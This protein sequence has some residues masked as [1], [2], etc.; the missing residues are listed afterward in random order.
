MEYAVAT[1]LV[2]L[3]IVAAIT[4]FRI[5][6]QHNHIDWEHP[7]A[8]L[9]DGWNRW[10]C[11]SYHRLRAQPLNLPSHGGAIIAANHFSG[12]D[13]FIVAALSPRPVRFLIA[14]EEYQRFGLQ[15]LFRAAGCIP[16]ERD[17][18]PQKAFRAAEGRCGPL[19]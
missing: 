10:F 5:V 16:V 2:V 1:A 11:R 12:L 9:V 14:K 6:Q 8:N 19:G 13:G 17:Q 18:L 3:V 7:W 4:T 15:W